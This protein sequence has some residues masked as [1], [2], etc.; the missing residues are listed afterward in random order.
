MHDRD[1]VG[2]CQGLCQKLYHTRSCGKC[3][4]GGYFVGRDRGLTVQNCQ[5]LCVEVVL[6]A[7][8]VR[9]AS[10]SVCISAAVSPGVMSRVVAREYQAV[11]GA[12]ELVSGVCV[13]SSGVCL[14]SLCRVESSLF[15]ESVHCTI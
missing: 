14:W 2:G 7:V 15:L 4:F 6:E 10:V 13:E 5:Q 11:S 8:S 9:G 1:F 3:C 12:R